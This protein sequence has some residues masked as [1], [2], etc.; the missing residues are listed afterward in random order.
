MKIKL[1]GVR[2]SL[3]TPLGNRE[4]RKKLNLILK[5]AIENKLNKEAQIKGF[6][7]DLPENLQY[8]YGGNTTCVTLTSKSGQTYVIDCG[9]GIRPLGD[10]LM[11]GDCSKGKGHIPIFITHTHWDHIQG[12]PFFK[13]IYVPG[14]V[15]DFYSPYKNL[16]KCLIEQMETPFFPV[17]WNSTA[18]TKK[19]N[20]IKPGKPL[21]L[22]DDLLL[23]CYPL[24]HPE[25]SYAYRFRQ[26]KKTFIFA[27]DA[28]FVGENLENLDDNYDFFNNADLL[29][30]DSQYT[31]AESFNKFTWGHTSFTIAVNCGVRWKAKQL[32]L[33]HHEPSYS[34]NK[35][36]ELYNEAIEHRNA[37][38]T[39]TPKLHI[40]R[41]GMVFNL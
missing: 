11:L 26:G 12:L 17:P 36:H 19:Y 10:E 13:P 4:Y 15:L 39:K 16:E 2:G 22:E 25:V 1:L 29:V 27:T 3:A 38:K 31:L 41:E 23:D 40:A 9:S 8:N 35:L 34:D 28:E 24:K 30:L 6:I 32:V 7:D 14:N 20:L 37:M 18:S 33:T 5:L 21:Q